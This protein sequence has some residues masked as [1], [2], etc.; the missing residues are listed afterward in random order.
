MYKLTL[1]LF[2]FVSGA[3]I[4]LQAQ[5]LT[6]NGA[7][8]F[9]TNGA[10]IYI[11]GDFEN[12]DDGNI[13]NSGE[14]SLTGN[15][16]NNASSGNLL[17]GSTGTVIFN[18]NPVQQIG[19]TA[20]TWFNN[21]I[22][23]SNT[24]MSVTTSVSNQLQLDGA[25]LALNNN[26]LFMGGTADITGA[27][28]SNYII[29]GGSGRLVRWV[30]SSNIYFPVGTLSSF[31]P[32]R[33]NNTGTAD[34]YGVRVIED[35]LTGGNSGS[36]IPEIDN[37]VN[38]SW[39][40]SELNTGGSDLTLTA[41]WK[42]SNEGPLFDRT[43]AGVGQYV[44]GSWDPQ[45]AQSATGSPIHSLTRTGITGT[46]T[47]AVGDVNS[48]MAITLDIVIDLKA[49]LEGPF[50]GTDMNPS[51]SSGF[52][53]LTQPYNVSP[54]NY[55][56]SENVVAIPN[57]NVVD[58]VLIEL[59]DAASANTANPATTIAQQAGFVLNDGSVV[60]TDGISNMQFNA[61]V[62]QNLYV[63]VYHRNHLGII[64]AN[65]LTQSGGIYSYDFTTDAY[66]ALGND[67]PQKEIATGVFGMYA[68]DINSNGSIGAADKNLWSSDAGKTGYL[69][70]DTNLDSEINNQDKNEKLIPNNGKSSNVPN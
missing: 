43:M 27:N 21:L 14:I 26:N 70:S 33:L 29:A 10:G 64:S 20:Q 42:N 57:A 50:N 18:G 3:I 19:G 69:N 47:F 49:F 16:T 60:S 44:S 68:G 17:Q 36:T 2:V 24:T 30:G 6:N 62:S 39:I 1:F 67:M 55:N 59:R 12:L 35:V 15:W 52:L 54:W 13:D 61:T 38:M 58:W 51:T 9:L 46:G 28:S 23:Q 56:G 22:L 48:P 8:I 41:Y 45:A 7:D 63:V 66:Q 37:C 32:V 4:K 31:N 11:N 5:T 25:K 65:A 34:Q 53:P 40:I